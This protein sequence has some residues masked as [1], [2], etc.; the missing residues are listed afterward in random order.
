MS[1]TDVGIMYVVMC[2]L[3][4]ETIYFDVD[5]YTIQYHTKLDTFLLKLHSCIC[6][7]GP[8]HCSFL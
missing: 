2:T 1:E 7:C 4:H 5:T 8:H 3:Y 6:L